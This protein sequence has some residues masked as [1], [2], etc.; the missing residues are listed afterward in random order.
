M[1]RVATGGGKDGATV[2]TEPSE[3]EE[4]T[5]GTGEHEIVRLEEVDLTV[6]REASITRTDNGTSKVDIARASEVE[7]LEAI[8][9]TG[10][11]LEGASIEKP[12]VAGPAPVDNTWVDERGETHGGD[13]VTLEGAALGTGSGDNGTG[14]RG[15]RPLEEP[16]SPA[17]VGR[18]HFVTEVVV[19]AS[20][21]TEGTVLAA[22]A[23][24]TASVTGVTESERV[25]N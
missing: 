18:R 17:G 21:V 14:S 19:L 10:G 24:T 16:H 2:E 3:H 7:E 1:G 11:T 4:E 25:A 12:G 13:E 15:E 6:L 23:A 22:T 5:T 9:G 8:T 20:K